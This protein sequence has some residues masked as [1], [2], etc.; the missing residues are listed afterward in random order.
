MQ[1]TR[2][3]IG[4]DERFSPDEYIEKYH[5]KK[6]RKLEKADG[7]CG[8]MQQLLRRTRCRRRA[9]ASSSGR[10]SKAGSPKPKASTHPFAAHLKYY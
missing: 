9:K 4:Y 1:T 10:C 2:T 6:K 5:R 8:R 3:K 7:E